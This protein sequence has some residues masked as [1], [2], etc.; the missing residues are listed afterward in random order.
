MDESRA[1]NPMNLTG[2]FIA[3]EVIINQPDK[4]PALQGGMARSVIASNREVDGFGWSDAQ[5]SLSKA[6]LSRSNTF[7]RTLNRMEIESGA[8]FE[9]LLRADNP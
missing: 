2:T 1:A 4:D 7:T 3:S 8:A 9:D 6:R 5:T